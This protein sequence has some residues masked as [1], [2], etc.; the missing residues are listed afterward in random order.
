METSR[1]KNWLPQSAT[2][3]T[4]PTTSP[5]VRPKGAQ[6]TRAPS[7]A[8]PPIHIITSSP[9]LSSDSEMPTEEPT[10][11]MVPSASPIPM[12]TISPTLPPVGTAKPVEM[13]VKR[14]GDR[15]NGGAP[16]H[17]RTSEAPTHIRPSMAHTSIPSFAPV[18]KESEMPTLSQHSDRPVEA[19]ERSISARPQEYMGTHAP[20]N[21]HHSDEN[22]NKPV[23]RSQTEKP[24]ESIGKEFSNKPVERSQT[25]KPAESKVKEFSNKPVEATQTVPVEAIVSGPGLAV[26]NDPLIPVRPSLDVNSDPSVVVPVLS[27]PG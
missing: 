10:E 17:P 2:E 4:T 18:V 15:I 11:G 3:D 7:R 14:T 9:T 13:K 24:V 12:L 27:V 20:T 19:S 5:S 8:R 26:D 6:G 23:E 25:E 1:A 22:T 21:V 16:V